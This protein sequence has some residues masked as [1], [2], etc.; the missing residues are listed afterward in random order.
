MFLEIVTT[1]S[2]CFIKSARE[3]VRATPLEQQAYVKHIK[4]SKLRCRDGRCWKSGY[5]EGRC[6]EGRCHWVPGSGGCPSAPIGT[7]Q[8]P[9][10]HWHPGTYWHPSILG[11]LRHPS[12]PSGTPRH[13]GTYWHPPVL[14]APSQ[15]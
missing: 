13:P 1:R 10:T 4:Y 2:S 3:R 12:A 7:H 8:H 5:W 14:L 11:T 9:G 6:W 15:S